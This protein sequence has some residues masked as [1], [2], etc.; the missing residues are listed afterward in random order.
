MKALQLGNIANAVF[1]AALGTARTGWHFY[2]ACECRIS[3]AIRNRA[4]N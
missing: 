2:A 4:T 3:P 1:Y